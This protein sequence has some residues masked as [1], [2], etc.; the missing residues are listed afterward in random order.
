MIAV[1]FEAD[2]Q[3]ETETRYFELASELKPLLNTIPGFID[4]ER[5]QSLRMQGKIL[6]LSWWED[7]KSIAIWKHNMAHASAQKKVKRI[8]FLTT[9][10]ELQKFFAIIHRKRRM[11]ILESK[12]TLPRL[13]HID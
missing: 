3:P 12:N 13:I 8:F 9:V 4:I 1:L 10:L 2:T 7:E 6:S 11:K 5:F